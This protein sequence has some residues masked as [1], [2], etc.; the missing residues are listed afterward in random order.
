MPDFNNFIICVVC[1][2]LWAVLVS[3]LF[4]RDNLLLAILVW[5]IGTI[6]LCITLSD[7]L[8]VILEYLITYYNEFPEP[9]TILEEGVL[10]KPMESLEKVKVNTTTK[11]IMEDGE[12]CKRPNT[13]LCPHLLCKFGLSSFTDKLGRRRHIIWLACFKRN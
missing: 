7:V 12:E 13:C 1:Y 8:G 10:T 6:F 9:N 5:W 2:L 4:R 11:I 3:Y